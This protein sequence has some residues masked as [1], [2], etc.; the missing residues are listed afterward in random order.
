MSSTVGPAFEAAEI[1][2][3]RVAFGALAS[4]R[5]D[6][7]RLPEAGSPIRVAFVGQRTYFELCSQRVAS[8]AIEPKF[9]DHRSG[10]DSSSLTAQ[11][12]TFDPHLVV[13]F[14]PELI[15]PG[16]FDSLHAPVLGVLT[17][18]LPR[19][20]DPTH[21][22]LARRLDD[23]AA[24]HAPSFDRIISF[25]PMIAET[26]QRYVPVWRSVPL[27]VADEVFGWN[28]SMSNPPKLLFIGR[29]TH[30]RDGFLVP[31]KHH[32]D[33]LHIDHGLFGDGFIDLARSG[34]DIAINVHNEPY[35]S[36]ENRVALHLAA[37][38]LVI[39]ERLSPSHGLEPDID[40]IEA[41][42]PEA[43]MAAVVRV[44][45]HPDAYGLMR[46]RGRLK[47]EGFRA[48]TVWARLLHDL[49]LDLSAFG[50]RRDG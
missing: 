15:A 6:G 47:A 30:H 50:G 42:T 5:P 41:S 38:H 39:S 16:S 37:G 20:G 22:D 7:I 21:P 31:L 25:D 3:S 2:T 23:L 17:E 46:W 19:T 9:F 49:L 24:V 11:M 28:P 14:R 13:V 27:P 12:A 34:C 10:F 40:F 43:M 35:P 1:D 48:S 33:L 36:F 18:P 32:F 4:L 29:S 26:A 8:P 45:N 44:R